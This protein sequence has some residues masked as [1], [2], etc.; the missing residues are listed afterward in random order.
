MSLVVEN[1]FLKQVLANLYPPEDPYIGRPAEW[2]ED[3]L[4]EEL[5]S[6]QKEI[7]EAVH[8]HD[9]V[10]VRAAHGPGKTRVVSRLALHWIETYPPGT[11]KVITTAPSFWQVRGLVWSEMLRGHRKGKVP[12]PD[13]TTGKR[14]PL[15]GRI[16]I[17]SV[18]EW[19]LDGDWVATG[20]KPPDPAAGTEDET[21]QTM[22][23]IH[24]DNLLII[25]DEACA[26]VRQMWMAISSLMTTGN[27]HVVAIGNPDD[28]DSHFAGLFKP[29]SSW[30]QIHIP[31]ARCP[32]F[33]GGKID[34]PLYQGPVWPEADKGIS[35]ELANKLPQKKFLDDFIEEWGMDGNAYQAKVLA[36]FPQSSKDG[37]IPFSSLNRCLQVELG[38]NPDHMIKMGWDVAGDG[39]DE[40]V[41]TS[42]QSDKFLSQTSWRKEDPM[43]GVG[44][45]V[46]AIREARQ[47]VSASSTGTHGIRVRV[48]VDAAGVG[49]GV[50]G[51]LKEVCRENGWH[52]VEINA[53]NSSERSNEPEIYL[54]QRAEM[55]WMA[56][57][58]IRDQVWDL[59]GLE[60]KCKGDWLAPKWKKNSRG[61]IQ[62]E[63]KDEIKKRLKRSPDHGESALLAAFD[64]PK[65]IVEVQQYKT[66]TLPGRR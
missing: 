21:I 44:N 31:L 23:G 35:E 47:M 18:C 26:V 2:I 43:E 38:V 12:D 9:K 34:I 15:R 36:E 64:P 53:V 10:A 33:Q 29:E 20:R 37:V 41:L 4:G 45:V 66:T 60:K 42:M 8:T 28:P 62:I 16:T 50:T 65:E 25:V 46:S 27:C 7:C 14:R 56:R 1:P 3:E 63:D 57:D 5:V 51:R 54:N 32:A 13:D 40:N 49:W 39:D 48:N 61:L 59:S 55:W 52:D 11:A 19:S 22:Q 30:H 6:Y 58:A 24:A 17:A